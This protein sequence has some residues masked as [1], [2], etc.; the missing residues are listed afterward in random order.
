MNEHNITYHW[1]DRSLL[2][3]IGNKI[4]K[5]I[6]ALYISEFILTAGMA[7]VFLLQSIPFK[8]NFI[9]WLAATGSA[10]LYLLAAYR[11]LARILYREQLLLDNNYLTIVRKTLLSRK[12]NRFEW[13]NIGMLHYEGKTPKTDHPLKGKSFDYFGFETQE[14]LIQSLHH[15]G[16]MYFDTP[17]GRVYFA[18]GVY[19][20]D[21]E[22]MVHMMKIYTGT[23]LYLGP[24]WE[25]MLQEYDENTNN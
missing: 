10:I 21:A 19:S 23:S 11:F 22:K 5:R 2:I 7:T 16:N 4:A 1:G 17:T 12:I 14:H 13:H 15:E 9:N 3:T 18:P 20:W 25:E 8:H 24:D 6:L